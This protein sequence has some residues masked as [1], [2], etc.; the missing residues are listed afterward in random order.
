[1]LLRQLVQGSGALSRVWVVGRNLAAIL[2]ET[3]I[4][5][6]RVRVD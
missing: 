1:M 4:E 5:A 3:V 2:K 6:T